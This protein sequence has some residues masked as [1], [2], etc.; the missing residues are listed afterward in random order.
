[1]GDAFCRCAA[2]DTDIGNSNAN[3]HDRCNCDE[4]SCRPNGHVVANGH[5]H[6]DAT[7]RNGYADSYIDA[8]D[9]DSY[10]GSSSQLRFDV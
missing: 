8:T 6:I 4:Y 1:M 2:L 7:H 3:A 9:G 5:A 10:A